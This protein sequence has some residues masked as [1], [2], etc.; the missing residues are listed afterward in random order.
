MATPG[1]SQLD[2]SEVIRESIYFVGETTGRRKVIPLEQEPDPRK[3]ALWACA[4]DNPERGDVLKFRFYPTTLPIEMQANV[5]S[6]TIAGRAMPAFQH[7]GGSGVKFNLELLFHDGFMPYDN[8]GRPLET[9]AKVA[10]TWFDM[11]VIGHDGGGIAL[12]HVYTYLQWGHRAPIRVIIHNVKLVTEMFDKNDDPMMVTAQVDLSVFEPVVYVSPFKPKAPPIVRSNAKSKPPAKNE[13]ALP[14]GCRMVCDGDLPTNGRPAEE[15]ALM[16]VDT[17]PPPAEATGVHQPSRDAFAAEQKK[18]LAK[19]G[20]PLFNDGTW[21]NSNNQPSGSKSASVQAFEREQAR[22][23]A[24]NG[25][26]F[27]FAGGQSIPGK[28]PGHQPSRRAYNS[29]VRDYAASHG[30]G[31]ATGGRR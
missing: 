30:A 26:S 24:N 14:P 10:Q 15:A 18:Y 5:A 31:W 12:P 28:A 27:A 9:K 13:C 8:N 29:S 22:V 7:L 2:P 6:E 4:P 11:Y 23:A 3:G 21:A 20:Y 16:S 25:A 17:T 19:N 1:V